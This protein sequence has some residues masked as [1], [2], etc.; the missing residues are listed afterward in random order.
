MLIVILHRDFDFQPDGE[1]VAIHSL[2]AVFVS[3]GGAM[4]SGTA[5]AL[6]LK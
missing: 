5:H 4:P 3:S 2:A 6:A 1:T